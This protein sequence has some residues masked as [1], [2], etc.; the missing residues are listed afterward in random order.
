MH[1]KNALSYQRRGSA[2]SRMKKA[3]SVATPEPPFDNPENIVT[4]AQQMAR[5]CLVEDV[6]LRRLTEA[7]GFAQLAMSAHSVKAQAQLAEALAKLEH[8]GQALIL[9]QQFQAAQSDPSKR[10]PL[11]PRIVTA[12]PTRTEPA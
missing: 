5:A 1:G 10:R 6:D 12:L 2:A 8:G 4:W 9:L 3:M 7:R 11:P